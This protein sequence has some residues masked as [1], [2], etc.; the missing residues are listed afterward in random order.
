MVIEIFLLLGVV[1]VLLMSMGFV[2]Q[3]LY[4]PASIDVALVRDGYRGLKICINQGTLVLPSLHRLIKV[5]LQSNKLVL[6]CTE[7]NAL[8]SKDNVNVE[9]DLEFIFHVEPTSE[10]IEKAARSLK[11]KTL[12]QKE[13]NDFIKN[14]F[15]NGVRQATATLTVDELNTNN[16]TLLE[17]V[18]DD[19]NINIK[20]NG[21]QL[22]SCTFI[23]ILS[24]QKEG[25]RTNKDRS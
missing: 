23:N 24:P 20:D 11:E 3:R 5:G 19:V 10:S 12:D 17:K 25:N 21:L 18:K 16:E 9:V 6:N 8:I 1:L 14:K 13:L 7:S 15:L 22:E 2:I 4:V